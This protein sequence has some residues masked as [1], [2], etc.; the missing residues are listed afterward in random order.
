MGSIA[1][2]SSASNER[3]ACASRRPPIH[4]GRLVQGKNWPSLLHRRWLL[5]ENLAQLSGAGPARLC[6]AVASLKSSSAC[7][8]PGIPPRRRGRAKRAG[9]WV[10]G[11]GRGR[12]PRAS[13]LARQRV[14]TGARDRLARTL[15]SFPTRCRSRKDPEAERATLGR[16]KRAGWQGGRRGRRARSAAYGVRPPRGNPGGGPHKPSVAFPNATSCVSRTRDSP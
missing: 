9:W 4:R 14:G 11:R 12:A 3:T 15:L 5:R 1:E 8:R 10:A 6:L 16:A 13:A 7:G 2:S